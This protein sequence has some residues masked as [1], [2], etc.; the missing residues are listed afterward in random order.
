LIW[1]YN[2]NETNAAVWKEKI[3]I[4][5]RHDRKMRLEGAKKQK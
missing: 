4:Q 5:Q 1:L 2:K 3:E